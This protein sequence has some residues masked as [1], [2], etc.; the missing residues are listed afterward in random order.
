[1]VPDVGHVA[2]VR[3]HVRPPAEFTLK[4]LRIAQRRAT[5]SGLAYVGENEI[6]RRPILFHESHQTAGRRRPGLAQHKNVVAL[7]IR[8]APP[9]LV[10]SFLSAPA[11]E[12]FQ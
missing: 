1:M 10:R 6:A 7:V 4:R 11:S 8:D 3:E 5:L 12:R 2:I 9:V